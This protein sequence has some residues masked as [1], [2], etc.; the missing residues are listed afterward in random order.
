MLWINP[1]EQ[2]IDQV[3]FATYTS[4]NGT[5]NHYANIVTDQPESM[6]LDGVDISGDFKQVSGSNT[7][8][9]AQKSLGTTAATHTL[10]SEGSNFIAHI[11]GFTKN[12]S[13]GYSAGGATKPLTQAITINGCPSTLQGMS[14]S[15]I[16]N[17]NR[18]I[19]TVI[20]ILSTAFCPTQRFEDLR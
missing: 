20:G 4:L 8:Y 7:Y 6:T 2:Q 18:P 15:L 14:I 11:Y 19:F 1:I 5:T 16:E 17:V 12:E 3:T 9:F 13:Y 10:K